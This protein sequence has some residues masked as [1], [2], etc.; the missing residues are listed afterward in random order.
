MH[1]ILEREASLLGGETRRLILG[2]SS[3][4]GTVALHAAMSYPRPLGAIILLRSLLVDS[5]TVVKD[6]RS[7]MAQTTPVFAFTAGDDSVYAVPLQRRGFRA[8][9][10]AG[11]HVEWHVE[12]RIDHWEDH[13]NELRCAAAWVARVAR[14][15]ALRE[16]ERA[17]SPDLG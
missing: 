7:E 10:S 5:V 3:Q 1:A 11:F 6:R 17:P 2:G 15:R 4:G 12:P 16:R 9:E 13:R 8:L 14:A